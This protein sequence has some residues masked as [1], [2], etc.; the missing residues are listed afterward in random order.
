M[1]LTRHLP[2]QQYWIQ[3]ISGQ[4]I[5]INDQ[6]WTESLLVAPY[7]APKRWQVT[8]AEALSAVDFEPALELEPDVVLLATGRRQRFPDIAIQRLLLERNVGLEVMTLEAAARTYNVLAS[9][10]RRVVG[11]LIWEAGYTSAAAGN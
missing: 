3:A 7:S 5:R 11:A 9:E 2:D 1:Q 4:A 10:E 8:G 6:T